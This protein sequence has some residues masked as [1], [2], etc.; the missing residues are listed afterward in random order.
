M[1]AS[2]V[3][4]LESGV[5]RSRLKG[6]FNEKTARFVSSMKEDERIFED[7]INGTEA[8]D[9]MLFEQEIITREDL[10]KIL[11]ALEKTR[12]K[13]K[14]GKLKLSP[15]FE[16][17]HEFIESQVIKEIGVE[18][19]GKLH[20][21]RSR[22]DQV[23][24]DLRMRVRSELNDVSRKVLDLVAALL[25]V[26]ENHTETLMALYTHTQPA[27][28]GV[29]AHYLL[30][31]ADALLRDFQRLQ[32]CYVKV[33]RSPLG[34]GPIGGSSLS[35]DRNRTASLLGFDGVLENSIDAV[36]SRDFALETAGALATLMSGLSRMAEDF[37]VWSSAEFGYVEIADEYASTSS[38]MPQ[39][40]N[41]CT[42][43]LIRGK[44]GQVYGALTSLL[45]MT[46]G[47]LTGYNRD[48]QE[49]K[50][51]LWLGFDAVKGSLEVLT[52][53]VST[54]KVNRN[55]TRK[56]AKESYVF[57]VDLAERLV[58]QV[59]ISFREAHILVGNLVKEM[60]ASG[61]KPRGLRA[62]MVEKLAVKVLGKKI[63]VSPELVKGTL[64]LR[65]CLVG[66][67]TLG[68]PAPREVKRM[69]R[70]RRKLLAREEARLAS[71]IEALD[72]SERLLRETVKK[73]VSK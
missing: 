33:N 65:S 70:S 52:G 63:K 67:K 13:I 40:K 17:I 48:L 62:E 7:D 41:P 2:G 47:V 23:A 43:E 28:I 60:V 71:R 51:P 6:K 27:Q 58:Q 22:N 53:I 30:A 24:V 69:L 38:V 56:A 49:T 19:G 20:S 50:L 42:L 11:S 10:K 72:E 21:G 46:K 26:A 29:F 66:R 1:L 44:T 57:A 39:K 5:Y 8:H 36:S 64:N 34:A 37:I 9:I 15:K 73:Y 14:T 12:L 35:I 32:D 16:D 54:L 18:V 25:K 45:T 31:Y 3:R 59:G 68:S 61:V 55:R 4:K